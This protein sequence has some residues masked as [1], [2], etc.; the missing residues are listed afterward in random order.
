MTA[1]DIDGKELAKQIRNRLKQTIEAE[2]MT[3]QLDIVLVGHDDSSEI[4]VRNKQKAAA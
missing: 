3:P 1:Y 4:Y 2:N